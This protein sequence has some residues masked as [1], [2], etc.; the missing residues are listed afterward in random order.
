MMILLEENFTKEELSDDPV[1]LIRTLEDVYDRCDVLRG[2]LPFSKLPNEMESS[3]NADFLIK[4]IT[5]AYNNGVVLDWS[6]TKQPK[7]CLYFQRT[8]RGWVLRDVGNDS[9]IALLGVG[10]YFVSKAAAQDAWEKFKYVWYQY[11]P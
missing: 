5:K 9:D 7:Y 2:Y 11:L 4:L 1:D 10:H 3:I 6:D 8:A